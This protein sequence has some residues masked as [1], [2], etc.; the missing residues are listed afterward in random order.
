MCGR[1]VNADTDDAIEY[2]NI[3]ETSVHLAVSW[4]VRPTSQI[5]IIIDHTDTKPEQEPIR[6]LRG[7]RWGLI[8]SW[9]TTL[10]KQRLLIN[11]RAETVL[12]KP[13]FRGAARHRRAIIPAQGYYEWTLNPDGSKTAFF[14]HNPDQP[15]LGFAGLYEWWHVPDTVT[16]PGMEDGWLC[17]ATIITRPAIDTLGHIHDRMPLI[18]PR[19][20]CADWLD[21]A[22]AEVERI[23]TLIHAIPDPTLI[24]TR[25][26]PA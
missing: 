17:T 4:D 2:F 8:P 14:L 16:L 20:M 5:G 18:V 24:P 6:Q 21:P 11:A 25:R 22:I 3:H 7:A 19:P 10:D 1:F 9:S 13:S 26:A 12:S 23:D 15:V